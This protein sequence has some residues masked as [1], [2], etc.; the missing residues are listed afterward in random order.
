MKLSFTLNYSTYPVCSGVHLEGV[1]VVS[2]CVPVE[3]NYMLLMRLL[4]EFVKRSAK[5][6]FSVRDVTSVCVCVF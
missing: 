2:H 1:T 6:Q 5:I 4:C 3:V